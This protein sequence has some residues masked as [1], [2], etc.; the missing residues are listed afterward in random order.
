MDVPLTRQQLRAAEMLDAV[1]IHRQ[2][3]VYKA[4]V[5]QR[6]GKRCSILSFP[7]LL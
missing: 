1:R 3:R 5:R 7:F 2:G 4:M 6:M